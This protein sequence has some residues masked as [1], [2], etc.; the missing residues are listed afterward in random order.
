MV[1][2]RGHGEISLVGW[3]V[4]DGP[5]RTVGDYIIKGHLNGKDLTVYLP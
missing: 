5:S 4:G 2:V 3:E 1:G